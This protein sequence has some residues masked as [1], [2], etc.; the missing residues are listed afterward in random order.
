MT[1]KRKSSSKRRPVRTKLGKDLENLVGT[2]IYST[3]IQMLRRLVPG[4]RT[5]RLS[6]LVAAMLQYAAQ[7]SAANR[8][9][10]AAWQLLQGAPYDPEVDDD[11]D[12]FDD[13][14]ISEDDGES[15]LP[16]IHAL[17]KEADVKWKRTNAR[18]Q[19]YSIADEALNQFQRWDFMPWE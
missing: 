3:W 17:F 4:G 5:E 6:V 11:D 15:I 19:A 2:E 18:G 7:S 13:Y 8:K 12:D 1:T 9:K 14:R 16:L 10:N